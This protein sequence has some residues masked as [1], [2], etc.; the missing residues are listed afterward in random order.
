MQ[1]CG[2]R[3]SRN[4]VWWGVVE[5]LW[6]TGEVVLLSFGARFGGMMQNMQSAVRN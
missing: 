2:V 1:V 6:G 3:V 5:G 4:V